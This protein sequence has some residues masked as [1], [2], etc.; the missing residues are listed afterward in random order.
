MTE[1]QR[2]TPKNSIEKM[3]N[4]AV[5]NLLEE[6]YKIVWEKKTTQLLQEMNKMENT[7]ALFISLISFVQYTNKFK[8]DGFFL[9]KQVFLTKEQ[10]EQNLQDLMLEWNFEK[11]VSIYNPVDNNFQVWLKIKAWW[12]KV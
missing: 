8:D 6:L 9:S 3:R 1:K 10:V 5:D 12:E 4:K 11:V 7:E 2:K